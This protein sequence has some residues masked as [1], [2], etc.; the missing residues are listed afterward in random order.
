MAESGFVLASIITDIRIGP[1]QGV[2][3]AANAI[4]IKIEPS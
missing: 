4:P 1:V 2:H 3:P